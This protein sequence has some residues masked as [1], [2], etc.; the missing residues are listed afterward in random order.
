VCSRWPHG[1]GH[2][3]LVGEMLPHLYFA[4]V[5]SFYLMWRRIMACGAMWCDVML[6]KV[7]AFTGRCWRDLFVFSILP[8]R[9]DEP[10]RAVVST[11]GWS[12]LLLFCVSVSSAEGCLYVSALEY[13]IF[14]H[15]GQ[16][17]FRYPLRGRYFSRLRNLWSD[18]GASCPLGRPIEGSFPSGEGSGAGSCLVLRLETSWS[19]LSR[20]V[21]RAVVH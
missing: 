4:W 3:S 11:H 13:R 17:G 8:S 20:P 14:W 2:H 21:L 5:T 18:T 15:P 12:N 6:W 10:E 1:C 19:N 9:P 7:C 16:F